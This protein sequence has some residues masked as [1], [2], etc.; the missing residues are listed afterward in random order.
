MTSRGANSQ[1]DPLGGNRAASPRQSQE[2]PHSSAGTPQPPQN[3]G[4]AL[5]EAIVALERVSIPSAPLAAELLLM[6]VLD[7]DRAWMYAHPEYRLTTEQQAAYA[8]LVGQ[9]AAGAPTQHL[10]GHQEFWGLDF[11]VTPAALIPRPET[12]HIIEVA[13]GRLATEEIRQGPLRI[14]DV[15]T[16]SGCIA[17][18]LAHEL[19]QAHVLATDISTAALEVARRN[20]ER[21]GVANRI[22]FLRTNILE[23]LFPRVT[24]PVAPRFDLIVSNPPYI[25]L[26]EAAG[27]PREVRDHEPHEALFAGEDGL[28]FYPQLIA[29]AQALLAPGGFLIMELAHH[30]AAPVRTLLQTPDWTAIAMDRDLADIERVISAERSS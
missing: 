21:H 17:V 29:Q 14:A 20:A 25:G 9:R 6:H 26:K 10:T 16:G 18:A 11:E 5:V 3:V 7:R 12:E 27:L 1:S 19:P 2:N 24:L 23:S 30:G 15:G 8:I 22:D 28:T 13:L 4:D